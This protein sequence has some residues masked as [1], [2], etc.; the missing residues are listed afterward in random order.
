MQAL[1]LALALLSALTSAVQAQGSST[2]T[3]YT[4]TVAAPGNA[5]LDGKSLRAD[6]NVDGK[7]GS[8]WLDGAP[9]SNFTITAP[10]PGTN[11]SAPDPVTWGVQFSD[12]SQFLHGMRGVVYVYTTPQNDGS[13]SYLSVTFARNG[14]TLYPYLAGT[15][16]TGPLPAQDGEFVACPDK[17]GQYFRLAVQGPPGSSFAIYQPGECAPLQLQLHPLQSG[18]VAPEQKTVQRLRRSR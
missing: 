13:L 9:G 14:S 5:T 12:T 7:A 3:L 6:M 16:P 11:S 1:I 17:S 15:D 8:V 4:I 2:N 18:V 10:I